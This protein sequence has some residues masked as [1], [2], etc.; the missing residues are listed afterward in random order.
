L[1]HMNVP[2]SPKWKGGKRWPASRK[3]NYI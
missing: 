1:P 2:S 3:R